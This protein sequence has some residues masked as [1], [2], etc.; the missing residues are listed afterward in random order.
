MPYIFQD[1][2]TM[3]SEKIEEWRKFANTYTEN[4]GEPAEMGD[5]LVKA[6]NDGT[7]KW[8]RYD[9]SGKMMKGWVTITGDLADIYPNQSGNTYFYDYATGL[10]AKGWTT[11]GGTRYR[12]D[13]ITG[14]LLEK[15]EPESDD[16]DYEAI[17]Y[18]AWGEPI[19]AKGKAI[20]DAA[21][22]QIGSTDL[23][24]VV[25]NNALNAIGVDGRAVYLFGW[26]LSTETIRDAGRHVD[27]PW[28]GDIAYY[29]SNYYGTSSHVAV[30]VGEG[31]VVSGNYNGSTQ[32]VPAYIGGQQ[33]QPEYYRY[34]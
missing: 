30:Y 15:E 18:T 8:V 28:P 31:K 19:T 26:G 33:S 11:I 5:Q 7:G 16:D 4:N 17:D 21:I 25:A 3:T 6:I 1:E 13:E 32:L 27:E 14:V 34:Y 9:A 23:C 2:K 20:A 12:F 22:A 24:S 10:M 29:A